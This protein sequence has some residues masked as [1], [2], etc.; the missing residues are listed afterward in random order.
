MLIF[1]SIYGQ[2][3]GQESK[4]EPEH[5]I[6]HQISFRHDND[7][8]TFTDRYYSS[9]LFLKYSRLLKRGLFS[10][11]QEQVSLEL[12][13]EIYTPS[14]TNTSNMAE[15]D[16]PYA[17]FL[18]LTAGWTYTKNDT[19]LETNL[20]IG[21]TGK[22]SGSGGF[23]RWY[24][25]VIN[26]PKSPTWAYEIDSSFHFNLY[27]QYSH[28]WQL[29]TG[30]FSVYFAVQPK[31]ALG[32]KDIYAYPEL[33]SYFGKRNTM[34]SSSAYNNL[35]SKDR[36]LFFALRA[37][38]RFIAHNAMLEGNLFG[39]HSPF[40][41]KSKAKVFYAGFDLQHRNGQNEYWFGYRFNSAETATTQSHKYI[42]L[43]YARNF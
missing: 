42:I 21:I 12:A 30:D 25:Q 28:E 41:V 22:T 40:L 34:S 16:R 38:Y 6:R 23:Q 32:T 1:G 39:D 37:G 4:S 43:S 33:I 27:G 5:E 10:S 11:G 8:L 15:M 7:F 9:G 36:E 2:A 3:L 24:H 20:L 17:G 35:G 26:I 18:G 29:A 13:Q 31:F 19:G 14:R